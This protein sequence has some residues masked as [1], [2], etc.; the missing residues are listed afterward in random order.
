MVF[1]PHREK[2]FWIPLNTAQIKNL[3]LLD[4]CKVGENDLMGDKKEN[5]HYEQQRAYH[6]RIES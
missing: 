4:S 1:S 3:L 5:F 2:T 6:H